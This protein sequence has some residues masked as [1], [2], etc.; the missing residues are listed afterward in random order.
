MPDETP[1]N[2][3]DWKKQAWGAPLLRVDRAWTRFEARLCAWV[4]VAE[5]IALCIWISLKGLSAEYGAGDRSG[6]VFR[7]LIGALV[8]GFG[9]HRLAMPKG[10]VTGQPPDDRANRTHALVVTAAILVGMFGARLWAN[11]GSTYFSNLLNW[12]QTASFLTLVGGLRGV[13]TRLTLWLAL[14]GG[15]LATAQGKHINIDVVMRFLTPKMRVPVAV[16]GWVAAAIMCFAG[17]WGFFDHIAIESFKSPAVEPC[18]RDSTKTCDAPAWKKI[19]HVGAE[20]G[21]DF[22][23]FR[24][25]LALDAKSFPKVMV[26][27]KYNEYLQA[28]TPI[29]RSGI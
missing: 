21:R 7:G 20:M 17:V 19:A 8:L 14:L 12:M 18:P 2:G 10:A 5:I 27:T 15:S 29:K 9:A 13:A 1:P 24:R 22:F 25:Q 23:L 16:L 26:G 3:E 28:I 11:S 6:L 4:L